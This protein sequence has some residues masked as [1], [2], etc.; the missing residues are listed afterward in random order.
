MGPSRFKDQTTGGRKNETFLGEN[1]ESHY[2]DFAHEIRVKMKNYTSI[3]GN[4]HGSVG[5]IM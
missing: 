5:K 3:K 2:Y 4:L 1:A